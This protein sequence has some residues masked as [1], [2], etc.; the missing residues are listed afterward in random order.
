MLECRENSLYSRL[1]KWKVMKLLWCAIPLRF[2][3]L[4]FPYCLSVYSKFL[5]ESTSV[6]DVKAKHSTLY[7]DSK[8][9]KLVRPRF[10][11]IRRALLPLDV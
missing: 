6:T 5:A 2:R 8:L 3:L 11:I 7:G 4:A 10:R 9:F 1:G